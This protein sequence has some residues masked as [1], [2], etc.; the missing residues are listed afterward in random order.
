MTINDAV[1]GGIERVRQLLAH[2]KVEQKIDA[3]LDVFEYGEA[4][5]DL[6]IQALQN[7]EVDVQEAAYW[8]LQESTEPRAKLALQA[9]N[10]YLFFEYLFTIERYTDQV[11]GIGHIFINVDKEVSVTLD[12]ND[13][14]VKI[15][16][17]Q[18]QQV[19]NTWKQENPTKFT[20]VIFA[21]DD[22]ILGLSHSND[23]A[24]VWD[25][26]IGEKIFTT[27]HHAENFWAV[28]FSPDGQKLVSTGD[29]NIFVLWNIHQIEENSSIEIPE[30]L[31]RRFSIY[32][33]S[34]TL[35]T[36]TSDKNYNTTLELWDWQTEQVF[37]TINT[38]SRFIPDV[39][40][41]P[42]RRLLISSSREN[43]TIKVWNIQTGHELCRLITNLSF[44]DCHTISSDGQR[45]FVWI[46]GSTFTAQVWGYP[47]SS[48]R[49]DTDELREKWDKAQNFVK[50]LAII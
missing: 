26:K 38:Q 23:C 30:Y 20:Q 16:N 31:P 28:S 1:L 47:S 50:M 35:V 25:L 43:G 34:Q 12:D 11:P 3:L 2:G 18:T 14:I 4:G 36:Y 37:C 24:E 9:Y 29:A 17:I 41:S 22:Q 45:L 5:L 49:A 10:P 44:I 8:L 39:D 21:P 7:S 19:T 48:G 13:G 6:I 15:W 27:G 32:S 40:I 46:G 42:D 33:N